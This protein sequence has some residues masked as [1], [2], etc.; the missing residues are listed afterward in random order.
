MI[1]GAA[2]PPGT[3]ALLDAILDVQE[4]LPDRLSHAIV[5]DTTFPEVAAQIPK[6]PR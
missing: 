5:L 4:Y 1:V 3:K 6:F 2:L